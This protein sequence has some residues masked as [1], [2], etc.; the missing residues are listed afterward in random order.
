MINAVVFYES[1]DLTSL[2]CFGRSST[3]TANNR[4]DNMPPC[5]TTFETVIKLDGDGSHLMHISCSLSN[6]IN[7]LVINSRL[8]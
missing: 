4:K 8:F 6:K 7:I 1:S 2:H 5:L 3:Y